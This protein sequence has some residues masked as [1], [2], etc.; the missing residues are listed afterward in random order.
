MSAA[1]NIVRKSTHFLRVG[2]GRSYGPP[3]R[4]HAA[5]DSVVPR[6]STTEVATVS[7]AS[8]TKAHNKIQELSWDPTYVDAGGE[9]RHRLHVREGAEEGPAQAGPAV[10]LPDGGGEGQPRLRRHG[11]R[12]PRQ[13]VPAGPGAL[14]GVA[15]ALPLHHPVPRDLRRPRHAA[16]DR[17]RAEPVD[18]QRPGHP[19]DRRGPPLDDPDEP[20]AALHEPLR[21][22]RRV[23][24]HREGVLELLRRHDRPPVRRGLHHRRRGH[25]RERLPDDRRRDGVHE[26]PVRGDARRGGRQRR[27][28]AADRLPLGAVRREPAHLQRLLDHPHGAR[29]R[30]QPPAARARPALRLVEQPR[31][32]RRRDRHLHR[33]R[34]EGPPQ[35]PRVLRRDVAALDLRRLLPLATSSRWRSTA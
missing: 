7:R 18:P 1:S 26:R 6:D 29:R 33:V 9:V 15:E 4:P 14:D 17:L 21:R 16:D 35:G 25:G 10:L 32:R 11:R 27:L 13:H 28:P 31:G 24:H 30:A 19:D 8:I 12:D 20:Q 23:R 5:R 22:P 2:P 3:S 34:H